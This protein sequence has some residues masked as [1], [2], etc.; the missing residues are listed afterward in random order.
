MELWSFNRQLTHEEYESYL[1]RQQGR[2]E[3]W[4]GVARKV[5]KTLLCGMGLCVGGAIVAVGIAM[6]VDDQHQAERR[7]EGE[8]KVEMVSPNGKHGTI[9]KADL[10]RARN[11]GFT[12]P[13]ELAGRCVQMKRTLGYSEREIADKYVGQPAHPAKAWGVPH[14]V[15]TGFGDCFLTYTQEPNSDPDIGPEER[16]RNPPLGRY[17]NWVCSE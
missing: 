10:E 8:E 9:R 6:Y 13:G 11:E 1:M 5:R 14:T 12:Y 2:Q 7:V 15:C 3:Y 17:I 4:K 16:T